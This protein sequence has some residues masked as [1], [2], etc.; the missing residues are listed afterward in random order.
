MVTNIILQWLTQDVGISKGGG[1]PIVL[2]PENCVK[3]KKDWTWGRPRH[4]LR[5][6]NQLNQVNVT[7]MFE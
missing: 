7:L 2:F 3:M 1:Q 4:H 5:S 6:S